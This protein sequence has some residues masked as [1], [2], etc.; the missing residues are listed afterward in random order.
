MRFVGRGYRAHDPA[1]SFA[2]L[3]GAGAALTGG[4]FN[5]KGEPALY[6]SLDVVTSF[7]ESTQG[8]TKRLQPFTMCEYDVDCDE[9]LDLSS[10]A[11]RAAQGVP[12]DAL[13]CAWLTFQLAGRQAPSWLVVDRLKTA[14]H[15]GILVPSFVP[16][17]TD[18][19]VNL[20]LWRWGPDRPHKVG[21][22]DP[23]GRLPRDQLS[24]SR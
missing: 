18:A 19:N 9:V 5:R 10:E 4:R 1:W 2:P 17:A 13:G 20:V 16:G 6:L 24:W 21:V 12:R 8:F 11:A 22:Y 15:V 3:S 7:G 23:A 14:G